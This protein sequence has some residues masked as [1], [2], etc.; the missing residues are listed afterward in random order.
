MVTSSGLKAGLNRASLVNNFVNLGQVGTKFDLIYWVFLAK[1]AVPGWY[2]VSTG[3]TVH[4]ACDCD[5]EPACSTVVGTRFDGRRALLT[6]FT[7]RSGPNVHIRYS[8]L[9]TFP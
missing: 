2:R 8:V 4:V 9:R 6:W 1:M 3:A 7:P 5:H